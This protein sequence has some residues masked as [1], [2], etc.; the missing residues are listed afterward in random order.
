MILLIPPTSSGRPPPAAAAAIAVGGL[1][2]LVGALTVASDAVGAVL[3]TVAAVMLLG[4]AAYALLVRPRLTLIR[5]D[6]P[7]IVVRTI[8]GRSTYGPADIDRI[9]LRTLR[10]IGRRT[11]QLE[12]EVVA[13]PG[14]PDPADSWNE[15]R[16]DLPA[17]PDHPRDTTLI[18][19]NRWDLGAD[20]HEV[21]D[22][23]SEAGFVTER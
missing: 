20:L 4:F 13:E 17:A 2:L 7:R 3:M 23:L 15:C 14:S 1:F 5:G 16:D 11:G 6:G 22:A 12:I 8:G 18:V 9:R 19:F 10:R 21:A